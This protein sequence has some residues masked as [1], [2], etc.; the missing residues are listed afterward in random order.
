MKHQSKRKKK[1]KK[2]KVSLFFVVI[3]DDF[4]Y[5][6][7]KEEKK[8]LFFLVVVCVTHQLSVL[9]LLPLL[10]TR[11]SQTHISWTCISDQL[12]EKTHWLAKTTH[13]YIFCSHWLT[14]LAY[15]RLGYKT[16]V[17]WLDLFTFANWLKKQTQTQAGW[18]Y[19]HWLVGRKNTHKHKHR[20]VGPG[21]ISW[22]LEHTG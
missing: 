10:F 9:T 4:L 8:H 22:L 18:T 20:M 7:F 14:R 21:H 16:H 11:A 19:L 6:I 15:T 13:T 5:F 12:T 3:K 1:E 2:G 17:G